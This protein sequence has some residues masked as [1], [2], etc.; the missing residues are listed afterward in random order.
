MLTA[1]A[2]RGIP[3]TTNILCDTALVYG[4]AEQRA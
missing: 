3:R 2:S 1:D 4:F